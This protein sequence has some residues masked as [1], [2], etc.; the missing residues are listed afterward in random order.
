MNTSDMVDVAIPTTS[1]YKC[2]PGDDTFIKTGNP[3]TIGYI[4][5]R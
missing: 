5:D 2:F 3:E 4:M 1:D